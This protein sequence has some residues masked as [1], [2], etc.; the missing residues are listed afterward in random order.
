MMRKVG[1]VS[2]RPFLLPEFLAQT[3]KAR[4]KS[5][6]LGASHAFRKSSEDR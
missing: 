5:D 6:A 4:F 2:P 1:A 3:S